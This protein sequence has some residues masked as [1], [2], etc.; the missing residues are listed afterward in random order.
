MVSPHYFVILTILLHIP[1]Y[2]REL[3]ERQQLRGHVLVTTAV[4][5]SN[6]IASIRII[7]VPSAHRPEHRSR[8]VYQRS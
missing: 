1:Y 4:S 3:R 2:G 8:G 5:H 6:H 7:A